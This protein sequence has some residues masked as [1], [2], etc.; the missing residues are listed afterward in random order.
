MLHRAKSCSFVPRLLWYFWFSFRE[1]K[2]LRQSLASSRSLGHFLRESLGA[3]SLFQDLPRRQGLTLLGDPTA[4]VVFYSDG[5]DCSLS[6]VRTFDSV[7]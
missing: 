5:G 7:V 4:A 2:E 1:R 6:F 3:M